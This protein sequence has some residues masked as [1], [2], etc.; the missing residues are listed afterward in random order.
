MYRLTDR[1][2]ASALVQTAFFMP[3]DVLSNRTRDGVTLSNGIRWRSE[4]FNRIN[5][6]GSD[7]GKLSCSSHTHKGAPARYGGHKKKCCSHHFVEKAVQTL[8]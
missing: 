2:L 5:G 6:D 7:G 4:N 3:F 8:M 1:I